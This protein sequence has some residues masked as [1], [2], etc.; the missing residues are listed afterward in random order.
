MPDEYVVVPE[1]TPP[2]PPRNV[3]YG[4]TRMADALASGEAF[5]PDFDVAVQRHR[6]LEAIERASETGV[7]ETLPG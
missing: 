2:G 4:Y 6:L 5:D 7:A 3:A 1:G